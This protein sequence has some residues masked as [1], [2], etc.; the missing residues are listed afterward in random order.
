METWSLI[1]NGVSEAEK[2]VIFHEPASFLTS[3][4]FTLHDL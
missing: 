1:T 4:D 3:F 2:G